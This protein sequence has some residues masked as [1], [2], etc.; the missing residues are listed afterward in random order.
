MQNLTVRKESIFSLRQKLTLGALTSL[1]LLFLFRYMNW[2]FSLNHLPGNW[3]GT[4]H[5]LDWS[6][7]GLLSFV[8]F[9]TSILNIGNLFAIWHA[10]K[11]KHE[12]PRENLKVAFLTCFVPGKEPIEM[13]AETLKA[14]KNVR[15][16]HDTWVLDEGNSAEVKKLCKDLDVKYFT[17][18]GIAKYN[19][20]E[21]Y[22]RAKTKAGNHNS[23]AD[24]NAKDYDIVAQ[25]DMDHVPEADYFEKTL[26]Y[27]KD[28]K[29]GFIGMPQFYKNTENWIS[30]GAAEQAFYFHSVLQ[31]G[32]YGCDMPFLIGTSHIYRTKALEQIGGYAPTIV[33]DHLT[34]MNFYAYGW[35]G[36]FVPEVLAKGEGPLNWVDY[37]NQ[38][39][40]WSY[41]LFEIF[42]K[43][44]PRLI[45]KL[46]WRQKINYF[47]SQLYYF[48]GVAV[49]IGIVLSF[50]YLVFGI[51]SANMSLFEWI[52]YSF[53]PFLI[54]Q[55]LLVYVHRFRIDPE[56]EPVFGM[57]GMFLNIGANL[58]YALAFIKFLTRGDLKYMV[59]KKG[60]AGRN[61]AVPLETFKF[62]I[63]VV[64]TMLFAFIYSFFAGNTALQLRFWALFNVLTLSAVVMSIYKQSALEKLA[65]YKLN[66]QPVKYSLNF[67]VGLIVF[68]SLMFSYT[69]YQGN[70][71]AIFD[72]QFAAS[73]QALIAGKVEVPQIGAYLGVSLYQHND[74]DYLSKLQSQTDKKFSIVGYY[75]SW[76]VDQNRFDNQWASN[77]DKN[78][79]IPMVTWEPWV[80]IS[81]FDRSES[82]VNQ[83]EYRLKNII[84]GKFDEYITKYAQDVKFYKKPL[85]IRFAHEM[86]GNW[87]PWGSTFNKPEEYVLA[88]RH[89]HEIFD[90]VGAT[91]VTWVWS[92]NEIYFES[93]VP[94]AHQI[95]LFYPGDDYVDWVGFSAFN[96]AGTYKN[97]VSKTPEMLY[98]NT[99]AKLKALNKPIILTE[100]ASADSADK[101][102]KAK[103]ISLAAKYLKE[104]PEIIGFVWFDASDN[105][106]NWTLSSSQE[107][108]DA[109]KSAF[110]S[111]FI[112]G[113]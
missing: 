34:G 4:A 31:Q 35:K 94:Y 61:Q 80:P 87:Y 74:T 43:H 68:S 73:Q 13:L 102:L 64:I 38:Q 22:F 7:F 36:V 66:L 5:L 21:G 90:S 112:Q 105:G 15:Y 79:S 30:K 39:M 109:F 33:E 11:P 9:I 46:K 59:T 53:P 67:A 2:W 103:W 107:S 1:F 55:T 49:V 12:K 78:G 14:M 75:Q 57:L 84:D 10:A 111:Y 100:T 82:V 91:N 110:D 26:G 8:V 52:K 42:F 24:T 16:A 51:R 60:S 77:I 50:I 85:I 95:E 3:Q 81:G 83:E 96:W 29:V 20:V 99:V 58:I 37:F 44:T 32:F 54:A 19:Q 93:R 63:A 97:N 108:L 113:K 62:H 17:R 69:Q 28:P 25:I 41:G 89:V 47:I 48:T 106:I 86:N 104:N 27:F 76:G 18:F 56:N 6:V 40:R 45:F 92:P 72:K 70:V 98:G 65:V 88:W 101:T 71:R 23:W